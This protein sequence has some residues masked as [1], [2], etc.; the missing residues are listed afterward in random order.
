MNVEK[1][2]NVNWNEL[3]CKIRL[4]RELRNISIEQMADK[5]S[6]TPRAYYYLESGKTTIT[7]F[8]MIEICNILNCTIDDMLKMNFS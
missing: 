2:Y 1:I 4:I 8:R 6:I 3:I 5:L 7:L